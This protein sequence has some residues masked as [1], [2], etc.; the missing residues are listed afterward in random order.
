MIDH[1][2][3]LSRVGDNWFQDSSFNKSVLNLREK[4]IRKNEGIISSSSS[5]SSQI[6]KIILTSTG[7]FEAVEEEE[8]VLK[9]FK[10]EYCFEVII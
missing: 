7:K 6:I 10:K 3:V 4:R 2:N 5:S 8:K 1:S 9:I